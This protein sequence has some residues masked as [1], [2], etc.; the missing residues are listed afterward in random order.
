[1][2]VSRPTL[3]DLDNTLSQIPYAW[4]KKIIEPEHHN[5]V[6]EFL[7]LWMRY[8]CIDVLEPEIYESIKDIP[9]RKAKDFI[10]TEDWNS[11]LNL[12]KKI[13]TLLHTYSDILG[14][15]GN[16]EKKQARD[17]YET[18][19]N[20]LQEVSDNTTISSQQYRYRLEALKCLRKLVIERPTW[21]IKIEDIQLN[22]RQIMKLTYDGEI[23]L[24]VL[25]TYDCDF[26][27]GTIISTPIRYF[28]VSKTEPFRG[29]PAL[30]RWFEKDLTYHPRTLGFYFAPFE[31][32]DIVEWW[33]GYENPKT[34]IYVI[35]MQGAFARF[36]D[37]GALAHF[38][39]FSTESG[40]FELV[41]IAKYAPERLT[42]FCMVEMLGYEYYKRIFVFRTNSV[43]NV[44]DYDEQGNPHGWM[45]I[46]PFRID[47]D[48]ITWCARALDSDHIVFAL[49][50]RDG[51]PVLMLTRSNGEPIWALRA[52]NLSGCITHTICKIDD[53]TALVVWGNVIYDQIGRPQSDRIYIVLVTKSGVQ[54]VLCTDWKIVQIK[55]DS[56]GNLLLLGRKGVY[57]PI[58]TQEGAL[59]KMSPDG[60][61]HWA[62]TLKVAEGPTT[63]AVPEF[64]D[65]V[66]DGEYYLFS[67]GWDVHLLAHSDW[68]LVPLIMKVNKQLLAELYEYPDENFEPLEIQHLN[69][70]WV[71]YLIPRTIS[72]TQYDISW[73]SFTPEFLMLPD[74][75]YMG[76][77]RYYSYE[78]DENFS[79]TP[80]PIPYIEEITY[81]EPI[82]LD[83][84]GLRG[85][86]SGG[87]YP[88]YHAFCILGR[89]IE[90][91]DGK[92]SLLFIKADL[93][94]NII[95]SKKIS[96]PGSLIPKDVITLPPGGIA[97][98]CEITEF[99][100]SDAAALVIILDN[101][102]N[103]EKAYGLSF[104]RYSTIPA[105]I[106][107]DD[108]K[109]VLFGGTNAVK[110]PYWTAF[111]T[112][113]ELN[114]NDPPGSIFNN[115][116]PTVVE[117]FP[118]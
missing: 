92:T 33:A 16:E 72:F 94:T 68:G 86:A 34:N 29:S 66:E 102:G 104:G 57:S 55:K 62:F 81:S 61:I 1:M 117:C 26:H 52:T 90:D 93:D 73:E 10:V 23:L 103:F 76:A 51:R 89:V 101:D 100:A 65:V 83:Y 27:L 115:S 59:I 7:E 39:K 74:R 63:A 6:K 110:Y 84:I 113:I 96:G 46:M 13:A 40:H 71:F 54:Q 118:H 58:A 95:F 70:K 49:T 14:I 109:L 108:G 17:A 99:G 9:E 12:M 19:L 50:D 80:P 77:L 43:G 48:K 60:A 36:D 105:S 56:D 22:R 88:A 15:D 47:S 44:I 11:I 28:T 67:T 64:Y 21:W 98:L 5:K 8:N 91:S 53:N 30:L 78:L 97:I 79:K 3:E 25:D 38:F 45:L 82:T 24:T 35:P 2:M 20:K 112:T 18:L 114:S 87:I 31:D 41:A 37:N 32:Y 107:W 106:L 111:I 85:F 69:F 116:Q 42:C 75:I 4:P